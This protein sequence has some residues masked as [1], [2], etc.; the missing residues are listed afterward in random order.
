[1]PRVLVLLLA[2]LATAAASTAS[3]DASVCAA[4]ADAD[5]KADV[6]ATLKGIGAKFD[7][8]DATVGA[9]AADVARVDAKVDALS[10]S[11]VTPAV[12]ARLEACASAL[13]VAV[14]IFKAAAP[15]EF[16]RQCTAVPMPA[17]L[18][19]AL[20]LPDLRASTLF[21]TAAHCFFENATLVGGPSTVA[22]DS[23]L[24]DCSLAAHLYEPLL[25]PGQLELDYAPDSL[26]LA[27]LKCSAGVPIPA[28]LLTELPY[29]AHAPAALVGFARGQHLDLRLE[30]HATF[31]NSGVSIRKTYALHVKISRLSRSFQTPEPPNATAPDAASSA[32]S[33]FV[34]DVMPPLLYAPASSDARAGFVDLTPWGGMSGGAIADTRWAS[35]ASSRSAACTRPAACL[36]ACSPPSSSA[37]QRPRAAQRRER[38]SG[39]SSTLLFGI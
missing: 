31:N 27:V 2:A 1:M 3:L 19:S 36:C 38:A 35:L 34:E 33:G 23:A 11:V 15:S 5:W 10:E 12:G 32:S 20:D 7:A 17:V 30:A 9:L 18:A 21:L 37:S 26:D 13:A 4:D 39:R 28:P 8:L 14:V 16:F 6:L 22:F 25:V 29:T 24:Y